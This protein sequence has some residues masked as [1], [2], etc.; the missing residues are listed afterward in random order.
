MTSLMRSLAAG[1]VQRALRR[2]LFVPTTPLRFAVT[3][4]P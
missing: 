2:Q 4:V 1:Y 3:P